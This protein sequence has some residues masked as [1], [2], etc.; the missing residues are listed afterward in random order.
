MIDKETD[1]LISNELQMLVD[2][3]LPCN[4]TRPK[5]HRANY[6]ISRY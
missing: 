2:E 4:S 1:R 5:K 6:G 3:T